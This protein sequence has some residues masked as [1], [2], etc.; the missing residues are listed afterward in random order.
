MILKDT[1]LCHKLKEIL[2]KE[3]E[4]LDIILFGSA[5]RGK[6]KPN[7]LDILIIFKNKINKET[8]YNIRKI[9]EKNYKNISIISKTEKTVLDVSFDAR[10]G[11]IFEGKSLITGKNITEKY[12]FSSFGMFKY[13]FGSWD[14]LQKTKFYYALNG[15][16]SQ[17]GIA[18]TL[19][20]IKLSDSL[21][22]VPL[23][24]IEKF[25]EFLESWKIRYIYIPTLIPER[26]S[27]KKILES[28]LART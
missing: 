13:N 16:S 23:S 19:N 1:S 20:C 26:L 28:I 17:K 15:R 7:D 5:V 10:E 4:I 14:K 2:K 3:P 24:N 22:L 9:I 12:G 11:F 21:M 18:E 27:R 25:R 6:E 8:E